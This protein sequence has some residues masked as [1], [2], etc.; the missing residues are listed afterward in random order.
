MIETISIEIAPIANKTFKPDEIEYKRIGKSVLS[1]R[2]MH[3]ILSCFDKFF[4]NF[5]F[6]KNIINCYQNKNE[7]HELK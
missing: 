7:A 6:I 5:D 3:S 1:I 4:S 2:S